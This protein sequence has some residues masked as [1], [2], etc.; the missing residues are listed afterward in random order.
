MR[1]IPD[2]VMAHI[3]NVEGI[4]PVNIVRVW[5]VSSGYIDYADREFSEYG[6]KGSLITLS[7]LEDVINLD[8]NSSS[9]TVSIRLDDSSGE[10]K[11]I[12]NNVDIHRKRVQIFQW[13]TE[14]GYDTKFV[15][16]EGEIASPVTWSESDRTLDFDVL[17][18]LEDREVGFSADEAS[19][20]HVPPEIV[21]KPWPLVFG[22]VNAVPAIQTIKV[23]TGLTASEIGTVD[24]KT[25]DLISSYNSKNAA[26]F[27]GLFQYY[28]LLAI[29]A[30]ATA[31]RY[32]VKQILD[33]QDGLDTDYSSI[34]E[35][36]EDM[37]DGFVE[38]ANQYLREYYDLING[39]SFDKAN[40]LE[41]KRI[42]KTSIPVTNAASFPQGK[43][44]T[45]K[46][47]GV[48]YTG[49][50]DRSQFH[51]TKRA[52]IGTD[53]YI[54]VGL[55]D[56]QEKEGFTKYVTQ[57][58]P[59][60][61]L[62]AQGGSDLRVG[63]G[64]PI[65]YIACIGHGQILG[66]QA[67]RSGILTGVPPNYYT[68]QHRTSNGFRYTVVIMKKPLSSVDSA[69]NDDIFLTI[70]GEVGNSMIDVMVWLIQTYTTYTYD[71]DSFGLVR[72]YTDQYPVNFVVMDQPQV[73]TLLK[74][75]AFQC[76][77]AIWFNDGKFFL[78]YLPIN[79]TPIE[80]ITPDDVDLGSVT[81]SYTNTEDVVT[82]FIATWKQK[83]SDQDSKVIFRNNIPKYGTIDRE[84][85]FFVYNDQRLVEKSAEFWT[86]RYSNTWKRITFRTY[87]H[88]LKIETW[89][90][91]TLAAELFVANV[92]VDAIVESSKYDS[93]S[94]KL[95]ISC[96]VPVRAGEMVPYPFAF[97]GNLPA[98][99]IYP[100]LNDPQAGSPTAPNATGAIYDQGPVR[101]PGNTSPPKR[102]RPRSDRGRN[103]P[104]GDDHDSGADYSVDVALDSR[105]VVPGT[106]PS[107]SGATLKQYSTKP[108]TVPP[109]EGQEDNGIY[110][111][112][113]ESRVQGKQYNVLVY[114][115]GNNKEPTKLICEQFRINDEDEIPPMTPVVVI[116]K[117]EAEEQSDR[118]VIYTRKFYMQVPVWI[119]PNADQ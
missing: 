106:S 22:V 55:T 72:S 16:F 63:D 67:Y 87:L 80:T 25:S 15:I 7:D 27:Q 83:Q 101:G 50:F 90:T 91:I 53:D 14:I 103:I 102:S 42:E 38:T 117:T 119:R 84:Y 8:Q 65:T 61:F 116:Q 104:I 19:F 108:V 44:A 29:Q 64:Y 100:V 6:V 45:Y 33:R 115:K 3:G 92:A 111:G 89:D 2:G 23:P 4:E 52:E 109:F 39:T 57:L 82:K 88:K 118:T 34:I 49:Y 37:G 48:T 31:S 114:T 75:I 69:W 9:T 95:N 36:F 26:A 78:R 98:E 51:V 35:Q 86:I 11:E 17:S 79:N 97:P 105:E 21:G 112:E 54:P 59:E 68:V 20:E 24:K 62:Y 96:W 46:V 41:R 66:V 70:Q 28:W 113:V 5:W 81:V 71:P 13:F 18:K 30:Y 99:Y 47:N 60:S 40:E 1:N 56:V 110:F 76:R 74:D 32:E 77:C 107:F 43:V 94:K 93:D 85:K 73:M 10:L 12:F 58:P